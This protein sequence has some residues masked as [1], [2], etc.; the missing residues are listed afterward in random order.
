MTAGMLGAEGLSTTTQMIFGVK[1][2][3]VEAIRH[4]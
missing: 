2:E 3:E 1:D 4:L